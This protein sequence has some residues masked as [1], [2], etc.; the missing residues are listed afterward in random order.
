MHDAIEK[1]VRKQLFPSITGKN[2]ITDE[3]R[4]LFALLKRMGRLDLLS[5][6]DIFRNYECSRANCDPLENAAIQK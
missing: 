3:D 5:N 4:S 2:Y 1:N 6:T